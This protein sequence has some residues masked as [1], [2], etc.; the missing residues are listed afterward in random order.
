MSEQH[1][2]AAVLPEAERVQ[3]VT[4]THTPGGRGA[5]NDVTG[6][7]QS[8]EISEGTGRTRLCA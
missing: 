5:V 2:P 3:C 8:G 7:V 4:A 6:G 1:A